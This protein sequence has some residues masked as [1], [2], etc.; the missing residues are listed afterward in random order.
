MQHPRVLIFCTFWCPCFH[1]L[2]FS[3]HALLWLRVS[4]SEREKL[5]YRLYTIYIAWLYLIYICN[6]TL[7]TVVLLYIFALGERRGV[8]IINVA[9][10]LIPYCCCDDG[11][12]WWKLWFAAF[13]LF[14][15]LLLWVNVVQQLCYEFDGLLVYKGYWYPWSWSISVTMVLYLFPLLYLYCICIYQLETIL[16]EWSG[17]PIHFKRYQ[18]FCQSKCLRCAQIRGL[19]TQVVSGIVIYT[20]GLF[21][22]IWIHWLWIVKNR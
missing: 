22:Y 20:R 4:Y 2:S 8:P 12:C 13:C 14:F 3:L 18:F 7:Y 1:Y 9:S 21:V 15:F 5:L 6:L 16:Y 11:K 10:P 17:S 19:M